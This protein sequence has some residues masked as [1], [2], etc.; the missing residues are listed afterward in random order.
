MN[1]AFF[2]GH[3]AQCPGSTGLEVVLS[4][5]LLAD[6]LSSPFTHKH[7]SMNEVIRLHDS[8]S[9][10][11][12]KPGWLLSSA[13]GPGFCQRG[14]CYSEDITC[15]IFSRKLDQR[16][17]NVLCPVC[18]S[19]SHSS[20]WSLSDIPSPPNSHMLTLCCQK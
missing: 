4:L 12:P 20:S 10:L 9:A 8:H 18:S 13:I 5:I 6:S 7:E 2:V 16:R 3:S 11:A 15:D 17:T 19:S 14:S 1:E